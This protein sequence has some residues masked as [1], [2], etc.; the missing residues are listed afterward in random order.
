ML[1]QALKR[2]GSRTSSSSPAFAPR[3]AISAAALKDIAPSELGRIVI[4]EA[5]ARAGVAADDVQH[6]VLG[7]VI[8]SEPRDAYVA[9]VAAVKAGVPSAAPAL[10][11]NRLCGSGVQA[12]ISAAQMI[13][14]GECTVAVAGGTESMSRSPHVSTGMRWGVKMGETKLLDAMIDTLTDPFGAG[15]MGMTAENVAQRYDV[16]R[17]GAGCAGGREPWPRGRARSPRG[18]SASRSC[19]SRS[20][21]AR[22]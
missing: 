12:I 5:I 8:P 16:D 6:V 22:A 15:H 4:A 21:R 9:R 20:R 13:Q 2:Q 10:T 19:P 7:Q 17:G 18:A 1:A 11:L 14:L 3:S